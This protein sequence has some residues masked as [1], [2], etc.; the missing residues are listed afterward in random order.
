[1]LD[2]NTRK[3]EHIHSEKSPCLTFK[4][5]GMCIIMLLK[6]TQR[7]D[8]QDKWFEDRLIN[9]GINLPEE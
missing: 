7:D 3:K 4:S 9:L 8:F 6:V 1:M 5:V 2:V